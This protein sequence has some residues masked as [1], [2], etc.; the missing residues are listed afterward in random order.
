MSAVARNGRCGVIAGSLGVQGRL[1]VRLHSGRVLVLDTTNLA[2]PSSS[3]ALAAVASFAGPKA[4]AKPVRGYWAMPPL[5][6]LFQ[7]VGVGSVEGSEGGSSQGGELLQQDSPRES[8]SVASS[9][10]HMEMDEPCCI[11]NNTRGV[12]LPTPM[13]QRRAMAPFRSRAS[14]LYVGSRD[15]RIGAARVECAAPALADGGRATLQQSNLSQA[16]EESRHI[17]NT[18]VGGWRIQGIFKHQVLAGLRV[19]DERWNTDNLHNFPRGKDC[20][21]VLSRGEAPGRLTGRD[22]SA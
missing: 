6:E 16:S 22:S 8:D 20:V 13:E 2:L 11:N 7:E 19:L 4:K 17:L 1:P 21:A 10:S 12:S 18:G 9:D 15:S 3:V 14:G 5:H